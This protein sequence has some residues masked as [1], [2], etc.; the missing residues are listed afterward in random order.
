MPLVSEGKKLKFTWEID[1]RTDLGT[2]S[3]DYIEV[4]GLGEDISAGLELYRFVDGQTHQGVW[5]SGYKDIMRANLTD[6]GE[7]YH[8]MTV[9]IV[10][11][12]PKDTSPD[13]FH[14]VLFHHYD[15]DAM[16]I[17]GN[18]ILMSEFF[19]G[20]GYD[21][22]LTLDGP[23]KAQG[24]FGYSTSTPHSSWTN[25]DYTFTRVGFGGKKMKVKR[26]TPSIV[27]LTN[28]KKDIKLTLK[29]KHLADGVMI[30]FDNKN[31]EVR[32]INYDSHKKVTI[33]VRPIKPIAKGT[34]ISLMAVNP[35]NNK[36]SKAAMLT[37]K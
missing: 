4:T 20:A 8:P 14:S 35:D 23:D 29:G 33:K 12:D 30:H 7:L 26:L 2:I 9:S 28:T 5:V 34:K 1:F 24:K 32:S 10:S 16:T 22:E 15:L 3:T 6:Y 18:T 13:N 11:A 27:P 25:F 31:L 21:Y 19:S 36:A 17:S 37:A